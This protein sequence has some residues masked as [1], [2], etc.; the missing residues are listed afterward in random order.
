MVK[1]PTI[2]EIIAKEGVDIDEGHA[3][4][5]NN[6]SGSVQINAQNVTLSHVTLN[7]GHALSTESISIPAKAPRVVKRESMTTDEEQAFEQGQWD[8]LDRRTR[9]L[10]KQEK[11]FQRRIKRR[12]QD[13]QHIVLYYTSVSILAVF[14]MLSTALP[15]IIAFSQ[16]VFD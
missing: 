3:A 9:D 5:H 11:A 15:L 10:N 8:G 12:K 13:R 1:K 4:S 2:D 6:A 14:V 7:A 16:G